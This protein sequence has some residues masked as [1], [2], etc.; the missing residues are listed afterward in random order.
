[1]LLEVKGGKNQS[2]SEHISKAESTVSTI[3]WHLPSTSIRT[4]SGATAAADFNTPWKK[5]RVES[6]NETL[7]ALGKTGRMG[8]QIGIFRS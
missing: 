2:D 7:C 8:L 3:N 4:D 1:M 5:F 6:R